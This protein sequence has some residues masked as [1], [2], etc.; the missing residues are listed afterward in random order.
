M[1][2]HMGWD[3][4]TIACTWA[5]AALWLLQ[6]NSCLSMFGYNCIYV[7]CWP[8]GRAQ[9]SDIFETLWCRGPVRAEPIFSVTTF[10]MMF[11]CTMGTTEL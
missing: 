3:A 8:D 10:S 1:Q 9:L 5:I 2:I 4:G 11:R 7:D 6:S